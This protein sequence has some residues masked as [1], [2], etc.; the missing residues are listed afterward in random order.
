MPTIY[1]SESGTTDDGRIVK[2]LAG[3][4]AAARD[5]T[6]GSAA[7]V[8]Y[9]SSASA[10]NVHRLSGRRG[11]TTY[12][13]GRSFFCFDTSGITGTVS[14]ATI[15]IQGYSQNSGS[16]IAVK[17]TAFG[18]DG[19]TALATGDFNAISGWSSGSSL[20]SSA[21]TYG[22]QIITTNWSTSGYNDF[23][24]TSDL[25]T[26]MQNDSVVIICL[27]DYTHDYLNNALTSDQSN[28]CGLYYAEQTGTSRDPAIEYTLAAVGATVHTINTVAEANIAAIK[29]IAHANIA[30]V[31]TVTFD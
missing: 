29:G 1:S 21:T 12:G 14:A 23:T 19:G 17:S 16:V 9:S 22:P 15:K 6:S 4:W 10:V 5:A 27:M 13:V 2:I 31:N 11:S 30:E 26:D 18:G 8:T 20:A 7:T 25:R 28:S 3:S 24:G